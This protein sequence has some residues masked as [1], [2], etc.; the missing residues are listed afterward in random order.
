MAK[1]YNVNYNQITLEVIQ[2]TFSKKVFI[3][4]IAKNK[5]NHFTIM[6]RLIKCK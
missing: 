6:I 4:N 2:I 5:N 3:K 1:I